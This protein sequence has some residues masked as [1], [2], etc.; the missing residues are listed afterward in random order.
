MFTIPVGLEG[1]KTLFRTDVFLWLP[2]FVSE[3]AAM[4][5]ELRKR[6][7]SLRAVGKNFNA[8]DEMTA[9]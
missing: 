8:S 3:I 2:K 6:G 4:Y 1:S 5:D 7:T 9:L